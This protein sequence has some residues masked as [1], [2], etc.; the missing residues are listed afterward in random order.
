MATWLGSSSDDSKLSSNGTAMLLVLLKHHLML[1]KSNGFLDG[2]VLTVL[3][4]CQYTRQPGASTNLTHYHTELL[5]I[6]PMDLKDFV[7]LLTRAII[8]F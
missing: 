6:Y 3:F 7:N 2:H 5:A 1:V 4:T 8:D